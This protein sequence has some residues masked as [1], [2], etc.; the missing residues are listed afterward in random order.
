MGGGGSGARVGAG[1]VAAE[2]SVCPRTFSEEMEARLESAA[3]QNRTK[4]VEWGAPNPL[5]EAA[6]LAVHR[7]HRVSCAGV[8]CA[9]ITVNGRAYTWGRGSC[10]EL[11]HGTDIKNTYKPT[12]V[13]SLTS[14]RVRDVRCGPSQTAFVTRSE[15]LLVTGLMCNTNY[16]TPE[17]IP[18]G[19]GESDELSI[20]SVNMSASVLYCIIEEDQVVKLMVLGDSS[21]GML[22]LGRSTMCTKKPTVV[23]FALEFVPCDIATGD[24]HVAVI[25]ECGKMYEW[26]ET[27]L[28]LAVQLSRLSTTW[29][30]RHVRIP[31]EVGKPVHVVCGRSS[32]FV[33]TSLGRVVAWGFNK[34][35][36]L[37]IGW[38]DPDLGQEPTVLPALENEHIIGI[39]CGGRVTAAWTREG[40]IWMWGRGNEGCLGSAK[41]SDTAIPKPITIP[42][43]TH[44]G[45]IKCGYT[46]CIALLY[47]DAGEGGAATRSP[48]DS[49]EGTPHTAMPGRSSSSTNATRA[50]RLSIRAGF[51]ASSM[52]VVRS[53]RS[54]QSISKDAMSSASMGALPV[55]P[56]GSSSP[57]VMARRSISRPD[58]QNTPVR[59]ETD[60]KGVYEVVREAQKVAPP[61]QLKCALATARKISLP[62]PVLSYMSPE[63]LQARD[64][65]HA[66][67]HQGAASGAPG[68]SPGSSHADMSLCSPKLDSASDSLLEW[69]RETV[70]SARRLCVLIFF[71]GSWCPFDR[72][73]L[74]AWSEYVE[75]AEEQNGLILGISTQDT[76]VTAS[77]ASLWG[78]QF[79]LLSDLYLE[80]TR[81]YGVTQGRVRNPLQQKNYSGSAGVMCQ[82]GVVLLQ[83]GKPVFTWTSTPQGGNLNGAANRP[84]P[85]S[86]WRVLESAQKPEEM[87]I[88]Q[89]ELHIEFRSRPTRG[90]SQERWSTEAAVEKLRSDLE[91]SHGDLVAFWSRV[92]S[93]SRY[94]VLIYFPGLWHLA[95]TLWLRRW[96]SVASELELAGCL[97]YAATTESQADMDATRIKGGYPIPL[98]G[99]GSS[100][101]LPQAHNMKISKRKGSPTGA[102]LPGLIIMNT[103]GD[104]IYQY[105]SSS[106]LLSSSTSLPDPLDIWKSLQMLIEDKASKLY[107][108]KKQRKTGQM[109]AYAKVNMSAPSN[110]PAYTNPHTNAE[111][112]A[113]KLL[114]L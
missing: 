11:G 24:H 5:E 51:M 15:R 50:R 26:G 14:E 33:L 68:T 80:L 69:L 86:V 87:M 111:Q 1:A 92:K 78:L 49:K 73:Y 79:P 110:T 48:S 31:K 25:G 74:Q 42:N 27:S 98:L 60:I 93:G 55:L 66:R 83:D 40:K 58:E 82:P 108:R 41:K 106:S 28:G 53:R 77:L 114:Q 96:E 45:D 22:G 75:R 71:R 107:E 109:H 100:L 38:N 88:A 59:R 30:P 52:G 43:A 21:K 32:T 81:E 67:P 39:H 3:S 4:V 101:A 13:A 85:D 105:V 54:S 57:A 44:L 36:V 9:A 20:R 35:G 8:H 18:C 64:V 12:R 46:R 23:P 89:S 70:F 104:V 102:V 63:Y 72:S 19:S 65:V 56:A 76:I 112:R 113:A 37:G 7:V 103:V 17:E 94:A 34:N 90:S 2:A 61:Q 91:E 29:E 95:S 6:S 47:D 97:L 99:L 62:R 10:G 84:C 16:W